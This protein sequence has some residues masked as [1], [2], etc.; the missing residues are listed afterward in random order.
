MAKDNHTTYLGLS[1]E[2]LSVAQT[3]LIGLPSFILF[4]YNQAGLGNALSLPVFGKHFPML[5]KIGK[6][7]SEL[8]NAS[9]LQGVVVSTFSL[10]AL[11]GAILCNFFGDKV[12]RK[13]AIYFGALLTFIGQALE[14]SAF[15]I[16]QLCIGRTVIGMGIGALN[17]TVPAWQSECSN[18]ENR[19][20]HVALDGAFISLGYTLTNW[21]GLA[22][23]VTHKESEVSWRIPVAIGVLFNLPLISSIFLPESP[24]WLITKGRLDE[25]KEI[26]SA[27]QKV[28]VDHEK[29]L[30]EV[31]IIA[32]SYRSSLTSSGSMRELFKMGEQ[33]ILMRFLMAMALQ[34]LQQM[35]GGNLI[36]VYSTTLYQE[37]L[38]MSGT[39]SRILSGCTLTFKFFCGFIAFFTVDRF[40][41]RPLIAASGT[42]M[43][44]CMMFL[45]ISTSQ[46]HNSHA[47][48]ASVFFIFAFNFFIP[49]GFL[50]LNWLYVV[51]ISPTRFRNQIAAFSSANNWIWNFVVTM[52]T[53]IAIQSIDYRYYIIYAVIGFLIPFMVYFF[54]PE[55]A[56]LTL[57]AID[58]VFI[59]ANSPFDVVA[60]AKRERKFL[61]NGD[62]TQNLHAEMLEKAEVLVVDRASMDSK[63]ERG[64]KP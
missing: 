9:T 30:E 60:T 3:L 5:S 11:V 16:S 33:K 39:L 12:G 20:K 47:N 18:P 55:T 32:D 59:K 1:G 2:A 15:H 52:I 43:A 10:G 27:F 41:R 17:I 57:E 7:G 63:N 6:E 58:L 14:C 21:I 31:E 26:I 25:A 19:G 23:Y 61:L 22:F 28:D 51:E 35:S 40:G 42:G 54:F 44:C 34:C 29:V 8:S 13:K 24:R 56:G 45:A 53:P 49:I 64:N 62:Q 46:K 4:G 48:I 37:N 38:G 50:G 36:S